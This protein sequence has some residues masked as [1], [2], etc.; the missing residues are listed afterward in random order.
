MQTIL[1]RAIHIGIAILTHK[2]TI[3]ICILLILI[4]IIHAQARTIREQ[5]DEIKWMRLMYR[6]HNN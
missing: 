4:I 2:Y 6:Q 5:E 3:E 1:I